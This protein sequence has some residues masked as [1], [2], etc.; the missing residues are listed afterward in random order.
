MKKKFTRREFLRISTAATAGVIAT[1][2]GGPATPEATEEVAVEEEAAAT[3]VPTPEPEKEATPA[4]PPSKYKEAPMLA[5]RV[6]AGELPP[7]DERL[8]EEPSIVPVV[9]EIGQYGGTATTGEPAG[10]MIGLD[11][12]FV[13]AVFQLMLRPTP[14]LT[15]AVPNL[16]KEWEMSEDAK[17]ITM[18]MRKGLKWSDGAPLTADDMV[19]RYEHVL[20]NEDLTPVIPPELSPGGEL[21]KVEKADDYTLT[22]KFAAPNPTFVLGS[23]AHYYGFSWGQFI[24]SHYLKEYH[25]DFN[26][27]ADAL[28]KEEGYDNWYELFLYKVDPDSNPERPA[29]E[30]YIITS[31]TSDTTIM[32]RN[33]Y[34]WQVDPEGN[35]LPY[36]DKVITDRLSDPEIYNVKVLSGEY[37][38]AGRATNIMNYAAYDDA[39]EQGDFRII[40]WNGG[41]GGEVVYE[42]NMNYDKDPV[43]RD[44]FRDVRFRRALSL[45]INRDEIND[46][47]YFG[48]AVPRQMTVLPDS[49]YFKEEFA[50]AY[51]EYDPDQANALL[52]EM[53]LE[54]DA[55][56]EYRL[57][58][59]GE[60]LKIFWDYYESETPKGPITELV[61]DHWKAVGVEINVKSISR[62][63]LSER[64]RANEEPLSLWHG[65]NVTDILFPM[66]RKWFVPAVKDS[67]AWCPLWAQWYE[68]NGEQ[69]EEPPD[70][71]KQI[72]EWWEN[73]RT[74]LDPEWAYKI[75]SAQAENVWSIGTVGL[76]PHPLIVKNNLRNV[77][78][79]GIFA[80][81]DLWTYPYYPE[82]W[83][84][85]PS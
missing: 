48:R 62:Q 56:H 60:P 36:I 63:L 43:L 76:A 57:R 80:W 52:D 37:D 53:G 9:E 2:C 18:H 59:D 8:P 54:W 84:F 78:E 25:I 38:F 41:K 51:A 61:R 45:A 47:I 15:G 69:G 6:E 5:E 3:P 22:F 21:M 39:A 64:I 55:N 35:Q 42:V 31:T 82:Q 17:T 85:K 81:D 30:A 70:E 66:E 19:F 46:V 13:G 10:W 11:A 12:W 44:I 16:V 77:A 79:D 27:D 20:Q 58:P 68:T 72:F 32:E 1:A 28:A 67:M 24:P 75:L 65:D 14:D 71:I 73:F 34:F 40:L 33:P 4:P 49:K 50:T 26:P 29:Y 74:T 83:F 23:M 7:V